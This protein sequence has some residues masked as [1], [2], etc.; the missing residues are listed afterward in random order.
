MYSSD[1]E[2]KNVPEILQQKEN[3]GFK[4]NKLDFEDENPYVFHDSKLDL[5]KEKNFDL[6]ENEFN[7]DKKVHINEQ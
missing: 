5:K 6:W 4:W 7:I 2:E 1:E 3:Y